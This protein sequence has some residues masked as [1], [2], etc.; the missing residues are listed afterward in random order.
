MKMTFEGG[1]QM[2][3]PLMPDKDYLCTFADGTGA[4]L[5][6]YIC[7]RMANLLQP[8][9]EIRRVFVSR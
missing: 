6:A 4:E 5:L 3:I 2:D 1:A 7:Q 9:Q 8:K